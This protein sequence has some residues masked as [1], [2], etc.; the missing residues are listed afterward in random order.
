MNKNLHFS[1][2]GK[3]VTLS[4]IEAFQMERSIAL[5]E[6]YKQFLLKYNGWEPNPYHFI[7]PGWDY[8]QSLVNELKGILWEQP[9]LKLVT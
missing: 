1:R 9:G 2:T 5:L 6:D 8:K 3:P 7:V 4:V